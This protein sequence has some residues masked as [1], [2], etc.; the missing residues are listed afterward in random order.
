[1]QQ[2][3][4]LQEAQ[5]IEDIIIADFQK[6]I[7]SL[8][9]AQVA[10]NYFEDDPENPKILV[11][12]NLVIQSLNQS[13]L[14]YQSII[15]KYPNLM[16]KIKLIKQHVKELC[17]EIKIQIKFNTII[18]EYLSFFTNKILDQQIALEDKKQFNV[19]QKESSNVSDLLSSLP[20]EKWN[21]DI[22]ISKEQI[23]AS[24]L[25]RK[26]KLFLEMQMLWI[27]TVTTKPK[28]EDYGKPLYLRAS[29]KSD[30]IF[31]GVAVCLCI[32][33]AYFMSQ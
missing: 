26:G 1:M 25:K 30:L 9:D 2:D 18:D 33:V 10:I 11:F 23:I 20:Q 31:F 15:T 28:V 22:F 13:K 5:I 29:Y 12:L 32:V 21:H 19:S 17:S 14:N 24:L 16:T 4:Q 8:T 7:I 27:N 6:V 3:N